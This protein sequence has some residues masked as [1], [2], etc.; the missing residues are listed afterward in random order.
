M[1]PLNEGRAHT[2]GR[3]WHGTAP[4]GMRCFLF[5]SV[6]VSVKHR[7]WNS[8]GSSLC[9]VV[10]LTFF[11]NCWHYKWVMLQRRGQLAYGLPSPSSSSSSYWVAT[12][13]S[14]IPPPYRRPASSLSF[15]SLDGDTGC[16]DKTCCPLQSRQVGHGASLW[17]MSLPA[18]WALSLQAMWVC[19]N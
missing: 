12:I 16:P 19:F 15:T 17:R 18:R 5:T 7:Y 11:F 4:H 3:H 10:W 1:C 6:S 8:T 13:I 14:L 2:Y 9:S